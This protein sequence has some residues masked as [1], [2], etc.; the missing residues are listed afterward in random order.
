MSSPTP[1]LDG[2]LQ[3]GVREHGI[4]GVVAAVADRKGVLYQHAVRAGADRQAV[5]MRQDTVFW[6]ASMTKAVTAAAAMQLVEQGR[7]SLDEPAVDVV[8]ALGGRQVLEGFDEDGRPRLRPA[9]TPITLRQLLTHTSG[10]GYEW[11]HPL[12]A[13]WCE[14]TGTPGILSCQNATLQTPLLFD[15][16]TR[17]E[18]G[19]GIDW[20]GKMVEAV[21]GQS[22]GDYL[23][24]NLLGPLGMNCTAFRL[25]PDQRSRLL[26][27]HARLPDGGVE[28]MP[29]EVPQDPEFQMGGGGLYGT[30]GDYLRFARMILGGGVLDGTRV[31]REETVALM[32][33]DQCPGLACG[34]FGTAAPTVSNA[35]DFF[36]GQP[37]GW[38]LSFLINREP[39]SGGREAGSLAWA[40][41]ANSYYWI[42]PRRGLAGVIATQ[43]LPFFDARMVDLL[44]RFERAVYARFVSA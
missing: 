5:P 37:S 24:Q 3:E 9:R 29:F 18:Y 2:L 22:I 43:I 1:D 42:D 44:R 11:V 15:P 38:G 35:A 20:A 34:A 33:A 4:P 36:P 16:G 23:Q 31:L 26:V 21:S 32:A 10:L 17:W 13:R 25:R 12:L 14:V 39:V 6:I 30:A 41:L 40:G 28:P 8:P 27:M 19:T 7:L